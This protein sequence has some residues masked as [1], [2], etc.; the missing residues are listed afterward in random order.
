M[1]HRQ[2]IARERPEVRGALS[3]TGVWERGLD[4]GEQTS[5]E[6]VQG[7]R[8]LDTHRTPPNIPTCPRGTDGKFAFLHEAGTNL[9]NA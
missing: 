4:A 1:S 8:K 9:T 7:A 6:E 3:L 5:N 2:G